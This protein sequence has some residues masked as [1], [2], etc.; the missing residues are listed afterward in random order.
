MDG[1]GV[2]GLIEEDTVIADAEAKH[3]LELAAERLDAARASFGIAVN[4]LQ[5]SHSGFL[6]DGADI[7]GNGGVEADRL[8]EFF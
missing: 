5:N 3:S 2:G 7:G 6:L 4:R 8:H 1:D